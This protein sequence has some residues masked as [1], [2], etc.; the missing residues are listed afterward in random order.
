MHTID[1]YSSMSTMWLLSS[2]APYCMTART[3]VAAFQTLTCCTKNPACHSEQSTYHH[4][5]IF[6]ADRTH[7]RS[8]SLKQ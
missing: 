1:A 3:H 8:M 6:I 7:C 4:P 2:N 5:N